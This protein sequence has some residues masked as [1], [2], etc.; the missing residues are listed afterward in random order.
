MATCSEEWA[1]AEI[2]KEIAG[3]RKPSESALQILYILLD[4]TE[5]QGYY[6]L[7][8][9]LRKAIHELAGLNTDLY[10]EYSR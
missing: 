3:L 7:L 1:V 2:E 10:D 9:S 8:D 6:E 4:F 5:Y